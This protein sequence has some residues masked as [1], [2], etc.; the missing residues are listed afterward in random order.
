LNNNFNGGN[1]AGFNLTNANFTGATLTGADLSGTDTR[2]T[3]GLNSAAAVVT[4]LIRPNGHVDGLDLSAGQVLAVRDYDGDPTR[5]PTPLAPG[6]LQTQPDLTAVR[7]YEE[8][9]TT[10]T[11]SYAP[12]AAELTTRLTGPLAVGNRDIGFIDDESYDVFYSDANGALNAQGRYL[13]IE[14]VWRQPELRGDGGMNINE[15]ELVFGGGNPHTQFGDFVASVQ[16]GSICDPGFGSNCIPGSEALAVDHNLSTFPRFG[17]TSTTNLDERFRLTVGFGSASNAITVDQ[18]FAMG[19]GGALRMVFEADAWDS[20]ISFAAGVPVALGGSLELAFAAGVDPISQIG[21]TFNVFDWTGVSPTGAFAVS[22]PYVWDLSHLY[23]TGEVTFLAASGLPG[24]FNG[25][26]VV[27]AADYTVWRDGLGKT[28]QPDALG[29]WK[30]H[31]GSGPGGG[32]ALLAS[33]P[34]S[35]V[36]PEPSAFFLLSVGLITVCATR[37]TR[38]TR[39]VGMLRSP[40][41]TFWVI[42]AMLVVSSGRVRADAPQVGLTKIANPVWKPVDYQL[43]SAPATPFDAEFGHVYDTLL[44]FDTA[45][46]YVPHA[47]PYDTELS[48]GMIAG[49]YMNQAVFTPDAITLHP[50]GVYFAFML[51]PDPGITG[52]SRD[53]GSGPVIPNSIFPIANNVDVWLDGVLVDRTPGADAIVPVQPRDVGKDGTSHLEFIQ[54]IWFPWDDDLTVGPLGNYEIRLSIRDVGGSGWDMVAP[55][56]VVPAITGDYDGNGTVGPEDYE[57]WKTNFGSTVL[58]AADGNG[59]HVIDAADYSVWRDHLGQVLAG[60]GGSALPS[61]APLSAGVPEP[62]GLALVAAGVLSAVLSYRRR[63]S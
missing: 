39:G 13:T 35:P 22:S 23:T 6:P 55:F 19:P 63:A 26:G 57:V 15:V 20:T 61:A 14:G 51:V 5:T 59:N 17:Q 44:P 25:D 27:N 30:K 31:F 50:N 34:Q 58:L 3:T 42:I 1:L 36:V 10:S 46:T 16:A 12:N 29:V 9:F 32:A 38:L 2:G 4:N 21:R 60:G 49:G 56:Q 24:D 11:L 7:V 62:S 8:T 28:Y 47:P 48:A 40:V 33:T 45:T 18:H 43:F 37:R 52:S 53:F 54:A 41:G